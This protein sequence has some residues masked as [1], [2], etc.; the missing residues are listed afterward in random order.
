[1]W[2]LPKPE[3]IA[4][5]PQDEPIGRAMDAFNQAVW[6][7]YPSETGV[8]DALQVIQTGVGFLH[9]VREWASAGGIT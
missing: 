8:D 2:Q 4:L 3:V 9:A 5:L 1:M 7:Y 6:A